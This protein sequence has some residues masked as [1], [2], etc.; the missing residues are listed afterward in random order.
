M[1]LIKNIDFLKNQI[2]RLIGKEE[3]KEDSLPLY[4]LPNRTE[5][6]SCF[7]NACLTFLLRFRPNGRYE[8]TGWTR[9]CEQLRS[10]V[11]YGAGRNS[12]NPRNLES[13]I[14]C[15]FPVGSQECAQE[16]C[17]IFLDRCSAD[18]YLSDVYWKIRTTT[19]ITGMMDRTMFCDLL[20][21]DGS[22]L[23][24]V[25]SILSIDTYKPSLGLALKHLWSRKTK[26]NGDNK[27]AITLRGKEVAKVDAEQ[28][29]ECK[30]IPDIAVVSLKFRITGQLVDVPHDNVNV[31]LEY[32]TSIPPIDNKIYSNSIDISFKCDDKALAPALMDS[33]NDFSRKKRESIKWS[34]LKKEE[35]YSKKF[36]LGKNCDYFDVPFKTNFLDEKE[37]AT[38]DLQA[39]VVHSGQPNAGHYFT[40][41]R[42]VNPDDM[43]QWYKVDDREVRTVSKNVV[44][45]TIVGGKT[46]EDGD[47]IGNQ[48]VAYILSYV[49][50]RRIRDIISNG[51]IL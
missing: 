41:I 46:D 49:R 17:T 1:N 18:G 25:E 43:E 14:M 21:K 28:T 5:W 42:F 20:P 22:Q 38:H 24:S 16:F 34:S 36:V 10:C 6:N 30:Q 48:P 9:L 51:I 3:S 12:N 27:F 39:V 15:G 19:N 23:N 11:I 37:S 32:D 47:M 35:T 33:I 50:T 26:L 29:I 7:A 45:N 40:Y 4:G 8:K 13:I 44:Q 2:N 31:P